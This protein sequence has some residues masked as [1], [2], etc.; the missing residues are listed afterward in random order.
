MSNQA[1]NNT[2]P[3]KLKTTP[4][5]TPENVEQALADLQS[6]HARHQA[7]MES[8]RLRKI[9]ARERHRRGWHRRKIAPI[10]IAY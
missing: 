3:K 6:R 7:L 2:M 10:H 8:Q 5:I 4:E 1:P 9:T